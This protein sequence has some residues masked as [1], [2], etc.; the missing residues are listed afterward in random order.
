MSPV[1]RA[2]APDQ[3]TDEITDQAIDQA[4]PDED[5]VRYAVYAQIEMAHAAF[6]A[7]H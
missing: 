7:S 4:R 6:Y 3:D 1:F 5:D 2:L